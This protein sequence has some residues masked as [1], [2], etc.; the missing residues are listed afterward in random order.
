MAMLGPC[1]DTISGKQKQIIKNSDPALTQVCWLLLFFLV[2]KF[3]CFMAKLLDVRVLPQ[4]TS[5]SH[6]QIHVN[7]SFSACQNHEQLLDVCVLPQQT[8][9]SHLQIRVNPCFRA[10][11]NN[12]TMPR[13]RLSG[14]W[15][16]SSSQHRPYCF[17]I[18]VC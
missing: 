13:L 6:L 14:A 4:Q 9:F 10:C 5:L 18:A 11:Q 3:L 2:R 1:T 16:R 17:E 15:P 12:E 8:S 7:P